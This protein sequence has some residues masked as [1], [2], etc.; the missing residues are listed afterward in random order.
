[1]RFSF[2]FRNILWAKCVFFSYVYAYITFIRFVSFV[3]QYKLQSFYIITLFTLFWRCFLCFFAPRLCEGTSSP[4][5]AEGR[6]S[7]GRGKMLRDVRKICG[8]WELMGGGGRGREREGR[9]S[10]MTWLAKW[11]LCNALPLFGCVCG[12]L[13]LRSLFH[14][15]DLAK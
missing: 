14:S 5:L 9:K 4:S 8:P 2:V 10:I 13:P 3:F 15:P 1:M 7:H 6:P 11:P 12:H